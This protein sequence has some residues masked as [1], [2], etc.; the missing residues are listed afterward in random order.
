M[1]YCP[2][3]RKLV[4][5]D[6][7]RTRRETIVVAEVICRDCRR[8]LATAH[9]PATRPQRPLTGGVGENKGQSPSGV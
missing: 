8:T 6:L 3:C 5:V 1:R 7:I 4:S 9:V 2:S